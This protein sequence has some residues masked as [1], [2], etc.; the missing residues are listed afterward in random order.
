MFGA[1]GWVRGWL[2][3]ASGGAPPTSTLDPVEL[4]LGGEFD[5]DLEQLAGQDSGNAIALGGGQEAVVL[6][7]SGARQTIIRL[8]GRYDAES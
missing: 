6:N 2:W 4:E 8:G 5:N 7:L 1:A 3:D